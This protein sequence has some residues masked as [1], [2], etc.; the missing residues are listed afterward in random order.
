M[1]LVYRKDESFVEPF[2]L[3][4]FIRE[5]P[6]TFADYLLQRSGSNLDIDDN[7]LIRFAREAVQSRQNNV[8]CIV[9][10]SWRFSDFDFAEQR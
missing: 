10:S 1:Y 3:T 5:Y 9:F 4:Q 2:T 6:M 7:A 8:D